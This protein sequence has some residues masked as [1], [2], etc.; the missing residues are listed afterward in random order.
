MSPMSISATGSPLEF[1]AAVGEIDS[2]VG[3]RGTRVLFLAVAREL[4]SKLY[5]VVVLHPR[6]VVYG[7]DVRRGRR[8]VVGSGTGNYGKAAII[9]RRVT[10]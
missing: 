7:I 8:K 4:D 5:G 6:D 9:R 10:G 2:A 3:A 1:D